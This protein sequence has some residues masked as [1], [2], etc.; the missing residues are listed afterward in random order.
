MSRIEARCRN[1]SAFRLRF[2]QSLASLR[3]RLS[4]ASVRSNELEAEGPVSR[5]KGRP[6]RKMGGTKSGLSLSRISLAGTRFVCRNRPIARQSDYRWFRIAPIA[7]DSPS[8]RVLNWH[9]ANG[10]G[11]P[12]GPT[13][14]G[15]ERYRLESHRLSKKPHPLGIE[16][17]SAR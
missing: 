15:P 5:R 9:S 2:S 11:G 10:R 1:A 4:Q 6:G 17:R 12:Y 13:T 3:Q 7:P 8:W 16:L 14:E